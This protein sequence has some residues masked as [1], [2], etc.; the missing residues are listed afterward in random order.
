MSSSKRSL[1]W[2]ALEDWC[3]HV[4][5]WTSI[6]SNHLSVHHSSKSYQKTPPY[7]FWLNTLR[8]KIN[9]TYPTTFCTVS[10]NFLSLPFN[11]SCVLLHY[12]IYSTSLS[13]AAPSSSRWNISIPF[14]INGIFWDTVEWKELSKC[15]DD[16]VL[17]LCRFILLMRSFGI[18]ED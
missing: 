14:E 17:Q 8:K 18:L 7:V 11:S 9:H 3:F 2:W 1:L 6:Q 13:I 15:N 5:F 4:Q 16:K 12:C 10:F